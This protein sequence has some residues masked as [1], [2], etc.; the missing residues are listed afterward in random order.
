LKFSGYQIRIDS[1]GK[2]YEVY[3]GCDGNF[4]KI[5]NYSLSSKISFSQGQG[6]TFYFPPLGENINIATNN[7]ILKNLSINK[8][9]NISITTNGI[10]E[11]NDSL[12]SC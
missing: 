5:Q 7:L 11:I 12:F 9:I 3:F 2:N 6:T 8:C 10:I 4:S 1:L